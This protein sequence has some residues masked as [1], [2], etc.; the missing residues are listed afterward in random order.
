MFPLLLPM[1]AVALGAYGFVG[2]KHA[3]RQEEMWKGIR[4]RAEGYPNGCEPLCGESDCTICICN[5]N[6]CQLLRSA[7]KS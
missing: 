7:R 3:Q 5:H 6:Y 4:E 1:L 2:M